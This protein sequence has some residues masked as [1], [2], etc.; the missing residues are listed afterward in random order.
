MTPEE[1]K[2]KQKLYYQKNRERIIANQTEYKKNNKD[3]RKINRVS[4]KDKIKEQRKIYYEKNKDKI[5][6]KQS[7]YYLDN[8]K[9]IN[10]YQ[11][12]YK[13]QNKERDRER[14]RLYY[15]NRLDND[16]LFKL[17][18]NFRRRIKFILTKNGFTKKNKSE[19]ILGCSFDDFKKYIESKFESW[20]TWENYGN[21]KDGILEINKTWD[22]DHV[23][24][25]AS[26]KTELEILRLNHYTNLQPLCSY[27]NRYIKR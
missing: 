18:S 14:L 8:L 16:P 6:Q 27:T 1:K 11:K 26:A 25:F 5:I 24:P 13:I 9:K 19:Q 21:P 23:I 20:M 2:E 12:Q 15:Q 17:K 7:Q 22:V 4:N 3:K 10:D